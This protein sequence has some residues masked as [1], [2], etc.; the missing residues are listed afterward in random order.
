MNLIICYTPLQV[1][2]A[3]RIIDLYPNEKFYGVMLCSAKNAK[4]DYYGQRL[5]QK[6]DRFFKMDQHIDRFNLLKEI[7]SLR[8]KFAFKKF[9]KVFVA[10]IND[11][12]IQFILS[13]IRFN[14]FYTFDDGTA[15]IIKNSLYYINEKIPSWKKMIWNFIGIDSYMEDIKKS[16]KKHYTLYENVSNIIE[17]TEYLKLF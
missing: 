13:S 10:S 2:I 3:E 1:L 14:A 5:A 17:N 12:Q 16:S 15:N 11:I 4:F 6:C 7:I 9:D 8:V